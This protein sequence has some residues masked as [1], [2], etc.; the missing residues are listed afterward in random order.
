M[1]SP[2]LLPNP[3]LPKAAPANASRANAAQAFRSRFLARI[4]TDV[5]ASFTEQQLDAVQRAFGM[6]YSTDHVV[7]VRRSVRLPWG[8]FYVV[9]LAGRDHRKEGHRPGLGKLVAALAL[10]ALSL[11]SVTV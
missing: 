7:D 3:A 10:G 11:L 9:L 6:R 2:A 8:R 4:P 1:R 5:A